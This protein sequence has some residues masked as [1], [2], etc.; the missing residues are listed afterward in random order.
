M[1]ATQRITRDDIESKFREIKG[2]VDTTVE[3]A[4]PIGMVVAVAASWL[5]SGSRTCSAAARSASAARSSR[6]SESETGV[7]G[8]VRRRLVGAALGRGVFGESRFWLVVAVRHR[9]P[10][11][12]PQACGRRAVIAVLE[13]SWAPATGCSSARHRTASE[14]SASQ[15]D[16]ASSTSP[17][18]SASTH[19]CSKLDMNRESVLVIRGRHAGDRRRAPG[20]RR[21]RRGAAG[22]LRRGVM[23]C[24]ACRQPP[25]IEVRRHNAAFCADCFIR[26]CREQM[27]Q[28]IR[29]FRHVHAR[30]SCAGGGVGRQGQLGAVGHAAR[31]R[32]PGRRLVSRARHRRVQ[33]R[34]GQLRAGVRGADAAQRS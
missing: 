31:P 29:A 25:V 21:S 16:A 11:R 3:R 20:R 14:G 24:R 22:D 27:R 15:P 30:R 2:D 34:V 17:A 33:R 19:C 23:K 32:V 6:S 12:R 18:R 5:R 7:A 9:R 8:L 13:P 1:T 4:K 10:L 28:A 26:H